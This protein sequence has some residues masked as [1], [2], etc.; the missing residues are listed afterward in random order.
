[1]TSTWDTSASTTAASRTEA[2]LNRKLGLSWR[3]RMLRRLPVDRSSRAV[4]SSPCRIKL[5]TTCEP[6]KPA[7]PVTSTRMSGG[8]C[9]RAGPLQEPAV[10]V[11]ELAQHPICAV[12]VHDHL[13]ACEPHRP[14]PRG[15]RDQLRYC[16]RKRTGIVARTQEAVQAG[17]DDVRDS[18]NLRS[19]NCSAGRAGLDERN[20]CAFVARA[21][22]DYIEVAIDRGQ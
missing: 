1:M 21:A 13:S 19:D 16:S 3:W 20:R 18:P 8:L 22:N 9:F 14:T 11:F 7:P 5:S 6:M 2:L 12:P 4:T 17:R 10:N 15:I